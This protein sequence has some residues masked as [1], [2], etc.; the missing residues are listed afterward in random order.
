MTDTKAVA[1]GYLLS[2]Y[3]LDVQVTVSDF[4]LW[5]VNTKA[6]ATSNVP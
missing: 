2:D 1:T 5:L 3:N 6:V 4:N